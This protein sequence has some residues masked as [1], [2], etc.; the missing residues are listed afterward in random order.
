V[1]DEVCCPICLNYDNDAGHL[2][3][4]CT[5]IMPLWWETLSWINTLTVFPERPK[6]HFLQHSQCNLNGLIQHIWNHRNK[7][8]FSGDSFDGKKL[9]DDALSF[10]W[11]WLKNLEKGFDIPF[12]LWSSN[13]RA[14]F[15]L[16]GGLDFRIFCRR[17]S[18]HRIDLFSCLISA[19]KC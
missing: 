10:C 3:F 17:V 9:M 4:G 5:K 2:F 15:F 8:V 19:F 16:Q 11:T 14:E 7:I 12:H 18:K 6:E 1:M 13:I